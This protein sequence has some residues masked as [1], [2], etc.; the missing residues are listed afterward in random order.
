MWHE[1]FGL[2]VGDEVFLNKFLGV[3][4][5]ALCALDADE[6]GEGGL[7]DRLDGAGE[8]LIGFLCGSEHGKAG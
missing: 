5:T 4:E 6:I 1:V 7:H 3:D 2:N 8:G